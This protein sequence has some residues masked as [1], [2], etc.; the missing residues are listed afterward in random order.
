MSQPVIRVGDKTSH[1]GEV[2]SGSAAFLI[3]GKPVARV[4]DK[5]SCPLHPTETVINS[6]SSA[7]LTDGQP[8]ARHGDSTACGATLIGSQSVYLIK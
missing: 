3:D 6:G 5:V 4:G 1:G 8:T 7:Y 2:L